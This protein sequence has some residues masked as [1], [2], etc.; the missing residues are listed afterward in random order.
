[1]AAEEA[2]RQSMTAERNAAN[3]AARERAFAAYRADQSR[4]GAEGEA[5]PQRWRWTA[6]DACEARTSKLSWRASAEAPHS[7]AVCLSQKRTDRYG[8]ALTVVATEHIHT[9]RYGWAPGRCSDLRTAA[10]SSDAR[11]GLPLS[12]VE[13]L[14]MDSSAPARDLVQMLR[15]PE[16]T[17]PAQTGKRRRM[18]AWSLPLLALASSVLLAAPSYAAGAS[19]EGRWVLVPEASS[20]NEAVTGLAPD[21]AVVRVTR[22][23]AK[24]FAYNVVESRDGVEVARASYAVVYAGGTGARR[25]DNTVLRVTAA[26]TTAGDVVITSPAVNGMHAWIRFRRTGD[27]TAEI[28]H[29]IEGPQGSTSLETLRLTRSTVASAD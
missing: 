20:F 6:N 2:V 15:E 9:V 29:E 17:R 27:N 11:F 19:L 24:R 1:M 5:R 28:Q 7:R 12:L 23:D 25:V 26:K 14:E 22:D 4:S 13:A 18:V 8:R 3:A 21:H 16:P 10:M